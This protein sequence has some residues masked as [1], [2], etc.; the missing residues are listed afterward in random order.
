MNKIQRETA[1][2]SIAFSSGL[3]RLQSKNTNEQSGL[4]PQ[5]ISKRST[6]KKLLRSIARRSYN[7]AK[8]IL[9]PLAFRARQYFVAGLQQEILAETRKEL[10]TSFA[11]LEQIKAKIEVSARRIIIPCGQ[12]E[13]IVKSEAGYIVCPTSNPAQ[14]ISLVETGDLESG[15]R[16]II[17]QLVGRHSIFVDVGANI[18]IYTIA[19]ASA[20]QGQGKIFA[21]EASAATR[22]LLEKTVL[23]NG[24]TAIIK[25][26]QAA[27]VRLDE[28]LTTN[29]K[30]DLI[31]ISVQ[32]SE[33]EVLDSGK[34]VI[35]DN[36]NLGLIVEFAPS[37]IKR[38]NRSIEQWFKAFAELELNYKVINSFTGE[39]E[40][41]SLKQLEAVDSVNLFFARQNSTAWKKATL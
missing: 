17:Q 38:S 15:T 11:M 18:G 37:L 41:W 40:N 22:Q 9:K 26:D 12:D 33:I 14:L 30:V 4:V 27:V 20:L 24:F 32:G 1:D 34:S 31:K 5:L 3:N 23:I 36:P 10:L 25:I 7:L 16:R 29:Q 35:Q 28:A 8:P 39:L 6:I 2:I 21:F 13:V 19:A